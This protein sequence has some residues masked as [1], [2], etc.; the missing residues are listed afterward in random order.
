MILKVSQNQ[1]SQSIC[2]D[3]EAGAFSA[4]IGQVSCQSCTIGYYTNATGLPFCFACG[5]GTISSSPSGATSCSNCGTGYYSG[6]VLFLCIFYVESFHSAVCLECP[7]GRF[8][9]VSGSSSCTACSI[10]IRF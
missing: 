5:P 8:G 4:Q 6:I 3:C 10:G 9:N 1:L 2:L 7:I